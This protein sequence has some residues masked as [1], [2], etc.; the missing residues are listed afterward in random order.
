MALVEQAEADGG[1]PDG[2]SYP[3]TPA[4]SLSTA[5]QQGSSGSPTNS[6]GWEASRIGVGT[7]SGRGDD[8]S[9][10]L[11][12]AKA[13]GV[14]PLPPDLGAVRWVNRS[15][16]GEGALFFLKGVDCNGVIVVRLG[17]GMKGEGGGSKCY[18]VFFG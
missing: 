17:M 15:M 7:G 18:F 9:A 14:P 3:S 6:G 8:A 12:R 5:G 2:Y 10:L 16:L 13:L 4:S 1:G 11:G